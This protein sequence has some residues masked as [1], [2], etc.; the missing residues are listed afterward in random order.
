MKK[1][2]HQHRTVAGI[3][4]E[5]QHK[6]PRTHLTLCPQ[7]QN[8]RKNRRTILVVKVTI[9]FCENSILGSRW[10]WRVRKGPFE[11]EPAF[12]F[13][14]SLFSIF[15]VSS[16]EK[17]FLSNTFRSWH[18]YHK[19]DHTCFLRCRCSMQMWC[20]DDTGRESWDWVR[21]PTWERA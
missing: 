11:G 15:P 7:T 2:Q 9:S 14:I 5:A 6:Q 21:P 13:F 4:T 10:T 20:P 12:M 1:G 8:V 16:F 17:I 3:A 19:F 18:E